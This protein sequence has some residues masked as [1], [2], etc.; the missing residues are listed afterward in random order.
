MLF[1]TRNSSPHSAHAAACASSAAHS[2]APPSR[3]IRSRSTQVTFISFTVP[4][5]LGGEAARASSANS[6]SPEIECFLKQFQK[7]RAS[8]RSPRAGILLL[9]KAKRLPAGDSS[10]LRALAQEPVSEKGVNLARLAP[11]SAILL[12]L[13]L[14]PLFSASGSGVRHSMC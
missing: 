4:P 1:Q 7:F 11:A 5:P 6:S 13:R 10:I 9:H 2:S 14:K 8:R 12:C 3:K